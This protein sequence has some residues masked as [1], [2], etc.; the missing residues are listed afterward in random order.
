VS[1]IFFLDLFINLFMSPNS[2]SW[3]PYLSKSLQTFSR[4]F[5]EL[6]T[7]FHGQKGNFRFSR[8]ILFAELN[9]PEI[10]KIQKVSK[11]NN[12][13]YAGVAL[14]ALVLE[15]QPLSWA[16]AHSSLHPSPKFFI[17]NLRFGE[18]S[19]ELFRPN[20]RIPTP[21]TTTKR[22]PSSFSTP[23]YICFMNP[24]PFHRVPISSCF[25][26]A[27]FHHGSPELLQ[28]QGRRWHIYSFGTKLVLSVKS[29]F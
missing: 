18:L 14:D 22:Q 1:L 17:Y 12:Y 19:D 29:S 5:S 15:V 3:V 10:K 26:P 23:W 13:I 24:S 28:A 27:R 16:A 4:D 20:R 11:P 21:A 8:I 7:I 2:F 9:N 25:S 6:R